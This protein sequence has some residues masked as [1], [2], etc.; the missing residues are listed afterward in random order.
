MSVIRR[1]VAAMLARLGLRLTRT[2][3]GAPAMLPDIAED[4]KTVIAEARE[5]TMTSQERL[6][7]VCESIRY[8][9]RRGLNGAVV[10]CGVWR[11]G[12]MLAA[13]RML[14]MLGNSSRELFLFDTFAGMTAPSEADVAI[15]GSPAKDLL[16][17]HARKED[18]GVWAWASLEDVKSTMRLSGYPAER[19][20]FVEGMVEETIPDK[21]PS[22]IALLRLDT[23][24]YESTAHELRHLIPRMVDG[25]VLIIDD[26]GHW[27]G[28]RKA[29]DEFFAAFEPPV[30]LNRVDYTGR[31]AII[32]RR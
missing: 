5:F 26:Y 21:A 8:I 7:A 10:E 28:A 4:V 24:W 14:K 13:A 11:G 16:D 25:G 9:E 19:I 17:S 2:T 6:N 20:H 3:P 30:L 29:V 12:S 27:Q 22:D 1:T 15:D 23:D 31:I 18:N 32:S